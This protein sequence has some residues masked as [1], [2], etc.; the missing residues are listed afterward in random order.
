MADIYRIQDKHGRGP[1]RPNFT[2]KW[3]E[4][5]HDLPSIIN[6][7]PNLK[8][9]IEPYY[10]NGFYLG[11][12]VRGTTGLNKWFSNTEISKLKSLGFSIVRC[13][14]VT[15]ICE[16]DNQLVFASNLPLKELPKESPHD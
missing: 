16:S 14:G 3:C 5:N 6:E 4:F 10:K 1:F 11:V 7:F 2:K 12:G 8:N 13:V 9:D 15:V